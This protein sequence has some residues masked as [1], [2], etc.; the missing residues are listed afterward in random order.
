MNNTF[1]IKESFSFAWE[2]FTKRPWFF[3]AVVLAVVVG[4][5]I[6][7]TIVQPDNA[8]GLLGYLAY[9]VFN[10]FLDMGLVSLALAAHRNVEMVNWKDL[11]APKMFWS[12]LLASLLTGAAVL[13]GLILLIIPGI[14]AAVGLL[15][16][17]YVVVDRELGPIEALKESWAITKG[18]RMKLLGLLALII[19]M[20]IAGAIVLVGLLVTMPLTMLIMVYVYRELEHDAHEVAAPAQSAPQVGGNI[21]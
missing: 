18:N 20:N 8:V 7:S 12:F 19:L 1:S 16:V 21:A 15:F 3:M 10:V 4:T 11:W 2:T 9:M 6:V 17:K 5:S 14:I 13:F